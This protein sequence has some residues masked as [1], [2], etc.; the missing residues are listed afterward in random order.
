VAE[1]LIGL[2]DL[3]GRLFSLFWF[4]RGISPGEGLTE[5][6]AAEDGR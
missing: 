4:E 3:S 6:L 5:D 2:P 1:L